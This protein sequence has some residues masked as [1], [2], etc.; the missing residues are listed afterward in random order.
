MSEKLRS[1]YCIAGIGESELGQLDRQSAINLNLIASKRALDDAGISAKEVDGVIAMS[2]SREG[3]SL[4]S[5]RLGELLGMM[6]LSFIL[7]LDL[8]GATA[9]AMVQ[10]AVMAMEAGMCRA[11]LCVLGGAGKMKAGEPHD[12]NEISQEEEEF[13]VPYGMFDIT[14]RYAMAARR[15]MHRYGTTSRQ[16]GLIAVAERA[17]ARLNPIATMKEPMTID[18]HQSSPWAVEPLRLLD[19]PFQSDGA[20]AFVVVPKARAKDLKCPPAFIMGMGQSHPHREILDSASLTTTGA[21]VSGEIA[22]RMAGLSLSDVD[23]AELSDPVTYAVLVQLEDYGF[24]KKGEA[25]AFL[26]SEGIELNKAKIPVN[27][28]GGLLSCADVPGILHITEAVKQ[29]RNGCGERQVAEAEVAL[30]SGSGG[31]MS[32]HMTLVLGK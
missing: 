13:Y 29:L 5:L 32:T 1:K 14:A 9:A 8:E 18:E 16:L 20:G 11:V 6:P 23:V 15:H 30:V 24:C 3:I 10:H 2:S 19:C 17:H 25:G 31:V 7:D 27:T 28:H 12:I 21:K 26:E 4:L 22:F